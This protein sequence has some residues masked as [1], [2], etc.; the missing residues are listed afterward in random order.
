MVLR[1]FQELTF[2]FTLIFILQTTARAIF[3]NQTAWHVTSLIEVCLTSS[4]SAF[5]SVRPPSLT[6]LRHSGS[7]LFAEPTRPSV[8]RVLPAPLPLLHCVH[9]SRE[10]LSYPSGMSQTCPYLPCIR[11]S[12]I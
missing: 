11:C 5:C 3:P 6:L 12:L 1:S 4:H 10:D 7:L 9:L 2:L 8:L